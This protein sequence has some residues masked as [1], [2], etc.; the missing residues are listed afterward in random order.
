MWSDVELRTTDR[1]LLIMYVDVSVAEPWRNIAAGLLISMIVSLLYA[2][3]WYVQTYASEEVN[4]IP[5]AR[6]RVTVSLK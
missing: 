3:P 4:A 6:L 1:A 5:Q 2:L